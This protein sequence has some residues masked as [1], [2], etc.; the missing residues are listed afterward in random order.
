MAYAKAAESDYS[1][2][3]VKGYYA[4]HLRSL[5]ILKALETQL[6]GN[7]DYLFELG[8]SYANTG[9]A[10]TV[11]GNVDEAMEYFK[12]AE[13]ILADLHERNPSD[14][15]RTMAVSTVNDMI[16]ELHTA[17]GRK[18]EAGYYLRRSGSFIFPLL[19]ANPDNAELHRSSAASYYSISQNECDL[20]NYDDARTNAEKGIELTENLLKR[21][22]QNFDLSLLYAALLYSRAK[23]LTRSGKAAEGLPILLDVFRR[24]KDLE[25]RDPE[26][27]II[28]VRIA[29]V[30]DEIGRAYL[31]IGLSAT[32]KIA[33]ITA[34]QKAR[35]S[36]QRAFDSYE[37]YGN[38]MVGSEAG[39]K[40]EV[41][42]KITQCDTALKSASAK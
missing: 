30:D 10:A 24:A 37:R 4:N 21:D 31:A 19:Q 36:L 35:S 29:Y 13:A 9:R 26:N 28:R 39:I 7:E 8:A 42:A 18:A 1:E 12:K 23:I 17:S 5:E 15:V 41:A 33:K 2:A 22:E 11:N 3:N 40:D 32:N 27:E 20:G 25:A 34:L 16:A 6:P 38:V 14:L